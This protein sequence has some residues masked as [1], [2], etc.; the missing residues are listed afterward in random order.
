MR[1]IGRGLDLRRARLLPDAVAGASLA[2]LAVPEVLGYARI[3]GMPVETGLY[4]LLAPAVVFALLGASRHLVVGAD[5]ATAAMLAAGLV[6]LAAVGSDRWVALAGTTAL[7]VAVLLVLARV[8]RLG[9]LA[10]FLSRTV[11]V[12]FLTGVGLSVAVGQLGE[13]L[14]L[15]IAAREVPARVVEIGRRIA[16]AD[17]VALGVAAA[18]VVL[19]LVLRRVDR[20]IPGALVAVVAAIVVSATVGLDVPHV[21]PV[22]AGLPVLVLPALSLDDV[23]AVFPV[24]LSMIVVIL[25]QSAATARSYAA[26]DG[27]AADIDQ[28]VV[29]LA[30]ANLAA[31]FTGTFVV[32]GSPTKTQLVASAGGRSQLAQLSAA[33]V[34]VVVVLF[35][36]PPLEILPLAALAAVVFVIGIELVDLAGLRRLWRVRRAEFALAV[37][38]AAAVVGLGVQTGILVA[39]ALSIADHLRHSYSPHSSVLR[40][41]PAGHWESL[42]VTPGARTAPGLVVYR[43]GSGLYF[44]NASRLVEDVTTLTGSGP[45]LR[46]F[47]LDAAAIGDVDY[48]A[49]AVLDQVRARL[50]AA[51]IRLVLSNVIPP[52]ADLLQRYGIIDALEPGSVFATSGEALD[53]LDAPAAE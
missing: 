15:E 30:G 20:R 41:S 37:A 28:D 51:G 26:R 17:G 44:A 11:L 24:A 39:V 43:F 22:P 49:G 10:N 46:W 35:L 13:M 47:C 27:E 19:V 34:T 7:V 4:T 3:A 42:A 33:V 12:G 5:S 38:T 45:P 21:G 50:R 31:A 40:K 1:W 16:E 32:N 53:A 2:A 8:V 25:A 36:T 48:T 6:G 29:G 14:G 52:V 23:R 9:A 18:V